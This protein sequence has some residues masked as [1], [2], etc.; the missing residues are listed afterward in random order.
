M[1]ARIN[2]TKS[3]W[4]F[5]R[6]SWTRA[7][8]PGSVDGR[9]SPYSWTTT[10]STPYVVMRQD[11][12]GKIESAEL[13]LSVKVTRYTSY[14]SGEGTKGDILIGV[15]RVPLTSGG[16]TTFFGGTCEKWTMPSTMTSSTILDGFIGGVFS[17]QGLNGGF[18]TISACEVYSGVLDLVM[19]PS[20]DIDE[21]DWP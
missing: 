6:T 18:P 16:T 4:G 20:I 21:E 2:P 13:Y 5:Y 17:T 1:A 11:Y 12:T 15:L 3:G 7:T 8:A 19:K 9:C 14:V 10:S